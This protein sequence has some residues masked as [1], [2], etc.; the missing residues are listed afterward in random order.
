MELLDNV[1]SINDRNRI[2]L[3]LEACLKKKVDNINVNFINYDR[4]DTVKV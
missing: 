4:K 2:K 1:Y 3:Y